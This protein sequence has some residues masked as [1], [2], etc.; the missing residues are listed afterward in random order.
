MINGLSFQSRV[1]TLLLPLN[2]WQYSSDCY[3]FIEIYLELKQFISTHSTRPSLL[4][5]HGRFLHLIWGKKNWLSMKD[6]DDE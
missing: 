2:P 6:A 5:I 3:Y 1:P 4:E